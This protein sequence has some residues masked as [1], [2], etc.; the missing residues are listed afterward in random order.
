[1]SI[2]PYKIAGAA[3]AGVLGSA[4]GVRE[5]LFVGGLGLVAA[6]LLL[7]FSPIRT[8]RALA[9]VADTVPHDS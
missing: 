6:T 8:I 9:D 7:A 5:T 4:V 2:D 3:L 1:M